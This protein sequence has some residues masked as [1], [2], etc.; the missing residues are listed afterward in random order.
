MPSRSTYHLTWVSLPW[1]WGISSRLL[2]QSAAAAPN[3]GRGVS[4]HG[5][6]S[7]PWAWSSTP[8]PSCNHAAASLGCRPWPRAY[9]SSSRPPPLT[10]SLLV[11]CKVV[12]SL[13]RTVWQFLTKPNSLNYITENMH[14]LIFIQTNW[15]LMFTQK[16]ANIF[17]NL[18]VNY[19]NLEATQMSFNV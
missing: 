17:R 1:T 5:C 7:W 12:L 3:L 2:Q 14:S 11:A 13:L 6:P 15:N 19:Q 9:G 4:S 8:R 16:P 18:I 10:Y